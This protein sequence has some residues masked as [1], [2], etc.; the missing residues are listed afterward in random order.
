MREIV[1]EQPELWMKLARV[2]GIATLYR[3]YVYPALMGARD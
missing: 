2:F 1:C 3:K